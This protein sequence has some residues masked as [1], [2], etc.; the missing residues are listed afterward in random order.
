T[1]TQEITIENPLDEQ[2]TFQT[3]ISNNNNFSINGDQDTVTVQPRSQAKINVIF[4][5]SSIGNGNEQKQQSKIS[6]LND[7][8]EQTQSAPQSTEKV[9]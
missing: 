6:F 3:V 2:V 4:N 5:P 7:K 8:I 1:S 9:T